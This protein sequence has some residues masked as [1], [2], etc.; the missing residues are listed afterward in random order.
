M[1]KQKSKYLIV[2]FIM[3][4]LSSFF[5]FAWHCE[6]SLTVTRYNVSTKKLDS[7]LK[8]AFI[9]DLHSREFGDNNIDLVNLI[10]EQDPDL[11][12]IGGDMVTMTDDNHNVIVELLQQLVEIAPTYYALGNHERAYEN[13]EKMGKDIKDTGTVLLDNDMVYFSK[14]SM[15]GEKILIGGLTDFPYYDCYYPDFD[16]PQSDFLDSFIKKQKN[17]LSVLLAHQPEFYFWTYGLKEKNLDLVL[18]G[19]THGGIIQL[20]FIGG[21]YAP[22]QG[23]FPEY[24]KGYFSS[25]TARMIITGGLGN[26]VFVPRLNNPPEICII[27]IN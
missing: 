5:I 27:N 25:E 2:L 6:N 23:L 1:K 12:A 15:E 8:I 3:L 7:S 24:D 18:S 9:S 11:I 16:N 10:S 13:F 22:N 20:P 19:H 21:L 14:D 26:S 4:L 17:T